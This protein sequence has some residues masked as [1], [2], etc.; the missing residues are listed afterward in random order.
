MGW[1]CIPTKLFQHKE[2]QTCNTHSAAGTSKPFI[3]MNLSSVRCNPV[4]KMLS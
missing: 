1:C 2:S 4:K 3:D